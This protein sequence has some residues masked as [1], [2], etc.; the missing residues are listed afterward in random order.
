VT[1]KLLLNRTRDG[2]HSLLDSNVFKGDSDQTAIVFVQTEQAP[3]VVSREDFRRECLKTAS[4]MESLGVSSRDLVIIAHTQDLES[5]YLFWGAIFLGAIPSIFHTVTEKISYDLYFTD[6][7]DLIDQTGAEVV[8]TTDAF[9]PLLAPKVRCQVYKSS[10]LQSS[11]ADFSAD[12]M[13]NSDEIALVQHSSGSTGAK[14]GVAFSHEAVLNQIAS[15]STA[16]RVDE[17]DVVVSWMPL[18]HDGGMIAG[19]ILP[20]VQGLPL[21]LMSPFDWVKHPG[22]L[23]RA[24]G[25]Y[26]GTLTWLPNFAY[27]HCVRRV[28]EKDIEGVRLDSVKAFINAA[29]PVREKSHRQF[30]EKFAPYGLEAEKL[31]VMYGMAENVLAITQTR[32]GEEPLVDVINRIALEEQRVAEP[33]DRDHPD[34][35]PVVSCGTPIAN[36]ELRVV[37]DDFQDLPDRHLGQLVVR[38]NCLFEEYYRQPDLTADAFHDGWH[39]TGDLGYMVQGEVFVTGRLKDLIIHAGKNVYPHDVEEIVNQVPG[40]HPG[41]VVAFGVFDEREGT[42]LIAVV[43]ESDSGD[44]QAQEALKYAIRDAVARRTTVTLAYVDI[45]DREW[46]IKTSSGKIPRSA[47]REKWMNEKFGK[48]ARST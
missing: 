17:D 41:R 40:V 35:F 20:L 33:V 45:V 7:P 2:F 39:L 37:D 48:E 11:A 1:V 22:I 14:K 9:A 34:A 24:I 4:A 8:F 16:L 31:T 19:H 47:N 29:E 27:N 21:V 46:M 12:R 10:D 13:P 25:E 23:F 43:A 30:L 38:S 26:Q 36:V 18:Y 6:M 42:E 3:V 44:D 32:L 15:Y 28:R 5:I